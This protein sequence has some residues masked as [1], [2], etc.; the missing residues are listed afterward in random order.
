[1]IRK[2]LLIAQ[3]TTFQTSFQVLDD[4]G[5]ECVPRD[6]S[7]WTARMQV[8]PSAE[9]ETVLLDLDSESLGGISIAASEGRVSISATATQTGAI[10]APAAYV[11]DLKGEQTSTGRVERWLGGIARIVPEVTR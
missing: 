3:G 7:G 2:Q 5:G 6:L 10:P 1:M 4:V 9:S 11:Y 8:R